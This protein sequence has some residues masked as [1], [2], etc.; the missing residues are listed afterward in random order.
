MCFY[1]PVGSKEMLDM[2]HQPVAVQS[3]KSVSGL[4]DRRMPEIDYP[5]QSLQT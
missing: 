3:S 4:T 5:A 1:A 2:A